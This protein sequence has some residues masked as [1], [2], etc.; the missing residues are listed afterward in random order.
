MCIYR[1]NYTIF[2]SIYIVGL[3]LNTIKLLTYN[4]VYYII[5][6][7]DW[8][9]ATLTWQIVHNIAKFKT[10]STKLI[11]LYGEQP[12]ILILKYLKYI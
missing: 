1:I 11:A 12:K 2:I 8:F 6:H 3:N 9:D 4:Y 7:K 10:E 5:L